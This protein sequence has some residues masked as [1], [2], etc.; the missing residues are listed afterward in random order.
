MR[1][2][3]VTFEINRKQEAA[4][5]KYSGGA[6]GYFMEQE[7]FDRLKDIIKVRNEQK[8]EDS[9]KDFD[10]KKEIEA[11]KALIIEKQSM[12]LEE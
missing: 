10:P 11:L 5:T 2:K 12:T 8:F 3:E 9:M 1:T 4:L 7:V 6:V